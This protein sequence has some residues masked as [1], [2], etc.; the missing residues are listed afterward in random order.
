MAELKALENASVCV[1]QDVPA[2]FERMP[3]LNG[4]APVER[5]VRFRTFRCYPLTGAIQSSAFDFDQA[6]SVERKQIDG[7]SDDA[8]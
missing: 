8:G 1:L 3:P 6:A 4:E 5:M 2:A 7:I